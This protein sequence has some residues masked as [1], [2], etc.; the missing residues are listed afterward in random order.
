[1]HTPAPNLV[2]VPA[3]DCHIAGASLLGLRVELDLSGLAFLLPERGGQERGGGHVREGCLRCIP[4]HPFPVR[5][6]GCFSAHTLSGMNGR[7]LAEKPSAARTP[8]FL[9]SSNVYTVIKICHPLLITWS[10][11][12]T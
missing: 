11:P 6:A 12:A 1:M 8:P 5:A 3:S 10:L 4:P 2:Q 9:E 7:L